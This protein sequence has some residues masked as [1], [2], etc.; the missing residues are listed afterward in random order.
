MVGRERGGRVAERVGGGEKDAKRSGWRK[1]RWRVAER[2]R[3]REA[4]GPGS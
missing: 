2:C 3:V 1:A 4:G